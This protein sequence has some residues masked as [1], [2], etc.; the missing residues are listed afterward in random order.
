MTQEE[1]KMLISLLK[2]ASEESLLN[3]YDSNDTYYYADWI[4]ND[5]TVNIKIKEL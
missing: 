3:I 4:W 5:T 1:L 2:K